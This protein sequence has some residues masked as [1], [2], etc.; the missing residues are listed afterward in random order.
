MMICR[1]LGR[2]TLNAQNN[3]FGPNDSDIFSFLSKKNEDI[4]MGTWQ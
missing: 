2:Y 4:M 1:W 3:V